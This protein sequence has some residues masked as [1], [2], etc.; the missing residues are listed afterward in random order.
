ML[1]C[2]MARA[3]F[4]CASLTPA[5]CQIWNTIECELEMEDG[6][7]RMQITS[8]LNQRRPGIK[9]PARL[10]PFS[11]NPL[12]HLWYGQHF[13]SAAAYFIGRVKF[14]DHL[15]WSDMNNVYITEL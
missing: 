12:W 5:H 4:A 15:L 11:V 9:P 1:H 6:W 3:Q 10:F 14:N 13:Q 8:E 2:G 7:I